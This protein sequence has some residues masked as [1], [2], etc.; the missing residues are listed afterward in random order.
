MPICDQSFTIYCVNVHL[1]K[2]EVQRKFKF[3]QI[4]HFKKRKKSSGSEFYMKNVFFLGTSCWCS[5]KIKNVG[6][7]LISCNF[8]LIA[9]Y[10]PPSQFH[11]FLAT[12]TWCTSKEHI[13]HVEFRSRRIFFFL[14]W[15]I[16][17]KLNLIAEAIFNS[18][19]R[20][21]IPVYITPVFGEEEL[22]LKRLSKNTSA[23]FKFSKTAWTD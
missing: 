4:F 17:K 19:I 16:W 1:S 13:F 5:S 23:R 18:K 12:S 10:E 2:M 3:F 15:K 8:S 21:G 6:G 7:G 14:K 11:N 9:A 22:K 20:Y